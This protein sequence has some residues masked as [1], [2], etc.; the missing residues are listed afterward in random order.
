MHPRISVNPVSTLTHSLDDDLRLYERIGVVRC[1]LH[2]TKLEDYGWD[3]AVTAVKKAGLQIP[4]VVHGVYTAVTDQTG[5][6]R[7]A[8]LLLQSVDVAAQLG[9][10]CV[11]LNVGP[12]G[13]LLWEAAAAEFCDRIRPVQAVADGSGIVVAL[14]NGHTSRPE[15]GFVHGAR[16]AVDLAHRVGPGIGVCVDL[17]CCW[18]E[19]GLFD[20]IRQ[21]L[22]FVKLVQVSDFVVGGLMQPDRRVPGDGDLPLRSLLRHLLEA[23]YAG[24]V[25]LELLGPAIEAEG[26]ESSVRRGVNWLST[27]LGQLEPDGGL[28]GPGD[29]ASYPHQAI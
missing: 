17:Y 19:P 14:E 29:R 4:Y 23:G 1:G 3:R 24:P 16:D 15:L 13:G 6:R 5:W 9:A 21:N 22:S 26:Y 12:S 20:T 7:E 10:A 2:T 28:R 11:Y 27:C 8:E 18:Q 25:D